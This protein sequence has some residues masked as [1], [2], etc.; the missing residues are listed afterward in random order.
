MNKKI[1]I[2]YLEVSANYNPWEFW[3]FLFEILATYYCKIFMGNGLV[4]A[5]WTCYVE[6]YVISSYCITEF[7]LCLLPPT[8]HAYVDAW[9]LGHFL[10]CSA[11]FI[12]TFI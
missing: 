11:F 10:T 12:Y 7:Y 5:F 2:V 4:Y 9:D 1:V 6:C 3:I 8:P